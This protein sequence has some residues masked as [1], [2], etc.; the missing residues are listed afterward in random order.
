[1][2]GHVC[3]VHAAVAFAFALLTCFFSI[4][5]KD[6]SKIEFVDRAVGQNI[7]KNYIPAIEK[8]RCTAIPRTSR[9]VTGGKDIHDGPLEGCSLF[10]VFFSL[11]SCSSRR[12]FVKLAKR[13]RSRAVSCR[14]CALS[15]RTVRLGMLSLFGSL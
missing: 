6:A 3:N 5:S 15:L 13:A 8:V 4:H 1:M 11:P 12:D 7:P 14:A 10:N 2:V 9:L